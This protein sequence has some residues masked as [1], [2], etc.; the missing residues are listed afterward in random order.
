MRNFSKLVE[1]VMN[2]ESPPEFEG[3]VKAMKKDD[4]VDNPWALAWWMKNRGYKSHKKSDGSDKKE[5]LGFEVEHPSLGTGR[6][7]EMTSTH[8]RVQ[9]D[10]LGSWTQNSE[11]I[12][13][14]EAG[15]VIVHDSP[16]YLREMSEDNTM[17]NIDLTG[18]DLQSLFE[19]DYY[20]NV[21]SPKDTILT[22][23]G[24][25]SSDGEDGPLSAMD[26]D[27]G[28]T[29]EPYEED[30]EPEDAPDTPP[31]ENSDN[32]SDNE[33]EVMK[34]ESFTL[35]DA[36]IE[37]MLD[38][39]DDHIKKDMDKMGHGMKEHNLAAGE[40]AVTQEFLKKMISAACDAGLDE[41]K[42]DMVV[43]CV[44]ECCEEDRTLDVDD[45]GM[46]MS[47]LKSKVDGADEAYSP[48][49]GEPAGD[50]APEDD[51]EGETKLMAGDCDD[52]DME[53][54]SQED[55]QRGNA[56]RKNFKKDKDR[57]HKGDKRRPKYGKPRTDGDEME[58]G[59]LPDALKKHQMKK[60]EDADGDG[61]T[62]EKK[63][64][65]ESRRSK[66]ARQQIDEAW[67]ASIPNM[68]NK[69]EKANTDGMEEEDIEIMDIRRLSG[70]S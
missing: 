21:P 27:G 67:L 42:I 61:K 65:K 13:L 25:F 4:D 19:E 32:N 64:F 5:S 60:G 50:D 37:G 70:M 14:K 29:N 40:I 58:E 57:F 47:K 59:E 15:R 28:A 62:G 17:T 33:E 12:N 38:E 20:V 46:I 1:R 63:P 16:K 51:M 34:N 18:N 6:V 69:R 11:C 68:G 23:P 2:E 26:G 24:E 31:V 56:K 9:W 7:V 43:S 44:A 3:T 49:D 35:E 66:K 54:G 10:R 45:I 52:E 48:G 8:A 30:Y 53:E 41:E 55:R 39:M 36:D 22:S